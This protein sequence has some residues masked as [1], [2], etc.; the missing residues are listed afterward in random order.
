[1]LSEEVPP[2]LIESLEKIDGDVVAQA[3][4]EVLLPIDSEV[5]L[6]LVFCALV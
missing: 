6:G 4:L 3:A 5:G 2:C 1:M